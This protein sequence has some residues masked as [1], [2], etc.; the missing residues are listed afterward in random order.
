[1]TDATL[2]DVLTAEWVVE[3]FNASGYADGRM[4]LSTT[5][6]AKE[7]MTDK[8][9]DLGMKTAGMS[10][11]VRWERIVRH[12]VESERHLA[13][14]SSYKSFFYNPPVFNTFYADRRFYM[15]FNLSILK[16]DLVLYVFTFLA[17]YYAHQFSYELYVY[18]SAN[19]APCYKYP[20]QFH[21]ELLRMFQR[22]TFSGIEDVSKIVSAIVLKNVLSKMLQ[23]MNG[24]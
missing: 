16:H 20:L 4:H 12:Y 5:K 23:Y 24:F 3:E 6:G 18:K 14:P 15:H 19:L 7:K 8:M 10:N 17:M 13:Q 1:M 9:K 2:P 22:Y 11:A 21:C